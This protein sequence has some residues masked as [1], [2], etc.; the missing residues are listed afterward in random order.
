[1]NNSK[2][3]SLLM[4]GTVGTELHT[5]VVASA[6]IAFVVVFTLNMGLVIACLAVTG[7]WLL[8]AITIITAY[9]ITGNDHIPR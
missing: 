9:P 6:Y 1:M 5:W 2:I 8:L 3:K 7:I 4:D